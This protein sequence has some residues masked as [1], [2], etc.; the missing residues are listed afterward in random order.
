MELLASARAWASLFL[1]QEDARPRPVVSLAQKLRF[2]RRFDESLVE[3]E[4]LLREFPQDLELWT[5]CFEIAWVDLH[6]RELAVE[7]H[8]KSLRATCDAEQWK[9]LNHRYLVQAHRHPDAG[10]WAEEERVAVERR[11]AFRAWAE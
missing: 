10:E 5:A 3:Y 7:F 1:P 8:R 4:H 2:N 6:D 9:K 11:T